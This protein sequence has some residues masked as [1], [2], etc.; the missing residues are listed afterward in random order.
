M[1]ISCSRGLQ[2][3]AAAHGVR[4]REMDSAAVPIAA[5]ALTAVLIVTAWNTSQDRIRS[6]IEL[7]QRRWVRWVRAN[8]MRADVVFITFF[9]VTGVGLGAMSGAVIATLGGGDLSI[10]GGEGAL[11]GV[12]VTIPS[13]VRGIRRIMGMRNE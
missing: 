4:R 5:L 2:W 7:G 1:T 12:F 9:A 10:R 8:P 13:V 6:N 11:V 3:A